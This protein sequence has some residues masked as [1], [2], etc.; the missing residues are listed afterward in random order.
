[1]DLI[2]T[3][4]DDDGPNKAIK[5]NSYQEAEDKLKGIK[6]GEL[7]GLWCAQET[8]GGKQMTTM[9]QLWV[10]ER[11]KGTWKACMPRSD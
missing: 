11:E 9:T 3:Y 1:M 8:P 10:R 7:A 5:V 4:H 6:D 2:I